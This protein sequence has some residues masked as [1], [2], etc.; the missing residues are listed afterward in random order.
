MA[1][2]CDAKDLRALVP[3]SFRDAALAD[4]AGGD[5]ADA[6]L[7]AAVLESSC[8]EV[9]ALIEGRVRLPLATVPRKLRVAA[10]HIALELLHIRRGLNLREDAAAKVQ[11]WRNW[12]SKVGEG[13]LP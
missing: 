5:E 10:A 4:S 9:D 2:Y 11:W 12:L 3:D 1:R 6:G 13:E 7:L 8:D